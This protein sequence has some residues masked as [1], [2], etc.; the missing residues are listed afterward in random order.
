MSRPGLHAFAVAACLA[1][2]T[3]AATGT[4]EPPETGSVAVVPEAPVPAP[5]ADTAPVVPAAARSI[6]WRVEVDS[7]LAFLGRQS[8]WVFLRNGSRHTAEEA[9]AH[10]RLKWKRQDGRIRSTDD[11][12]DLCATRSSFTGRAY[13]VRFPDGS[14]RDAADVLREELE[15]VRKD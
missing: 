4:T 11:F 12:I 3:G 2:G 6:P 9:V 13:R 1:A 7:L 5:A 10:L 14:E 15:R 8:D